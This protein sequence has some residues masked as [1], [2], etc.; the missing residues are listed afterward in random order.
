MQAFVNTAVDAARKAGN[1]II[2]QFGQLD[3]IKVQTKARNEFVTHVDQQ[4]EDAI[5]ETIRQRYPDHSFLG[6]ENGNI[7]GADKDHVWIIDPLDGTTNFIHGFPVFC[8]SIALQ[9]K[10]RLSA[11]VIYD[12]TRDEL[13]TAA[14]GEG[15]VLDGR[16][17]RVSKQREL[18]GSLIATGFPYRSS[19]NYLDTYLKMFTGVMGVAAGVRRPGA[20]ALDLAYV[21]A[22]RVDGF[23]E[24]GLKPWDIAAGVLLIREA[25]GI[26]SPIYDGDDY[27]E[28]GNLMAGTPKV[29]D[30]LK[31]LLNT[32]TK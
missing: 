10:G 8:V 16:R 21:A 29:H 7:E 19:A 26:V 4:A 22:G 9:I 24:F 28:S 6:E 23:W 25:G 1:I 32:H 31:A 20:A 3:R 13:F 14:R 15:A 27:M 12:P 18:Q 17:I 5:I 11:A 30:E 2:R